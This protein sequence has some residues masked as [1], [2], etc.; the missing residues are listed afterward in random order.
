MSGL[1]HDF[2]SSSLSDTKRYRELK[3]SSGSRAFG[4]GVIRFRVTDFDPNPGVGNYEISSPNPLLKRSP[5]LSSKGYGICK[6][7]KQP[8]FPDK[9]KAI[10]H[11]S[12]VY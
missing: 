11:Y 7:P 6:S 10:V 9:G 8:I 1:L 2:H 3:S 12:L 4:S 5:S